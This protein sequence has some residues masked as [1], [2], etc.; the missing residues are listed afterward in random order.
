MATKLELEK[1]VKALEKSLIDL[2]KNCKHENDLRERITEERNYFRESLGVEKQK[3]ENLL[4]FIVGA[5]NM[6]AFPEEKNEV[7]PLDKN[8]MS[9]AE[10]LGQLFASLS[11]LMNS[12]DQEEVEKLDILG[13]RLKEVVE[14]RKLI[15]SIIDS[16]EI[17][18]EEV[19]CLDACDQLAFIKHKMGEMEALL[20]GSY[21]RATTEGLFR[22]KLI[23]VANGK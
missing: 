2:G 15:S 18:P 13:D 5:S 22:L 21:D 6:L 14:E 7:D 23:T 20:K 8:L 17:V 12:F 10:F 11:S 4:R 19:T 3:S 1:Q 16:L 9:P